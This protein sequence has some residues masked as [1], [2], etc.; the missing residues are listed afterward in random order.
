MASTTNRDCFI[1]GAIMK[2]A[3]VSPCKNGDRWLETEDL[4]IFQSSQ[5]QKSKLDVGEDAC[6]LQSQQ[7]LPTV[8]LSLE[9]IRAEKCIFL[10]FQLKWKSLSLS[11]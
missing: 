5:L 9:D 8:L 3:H 2:E 10:P 4:A 1:N 7:D 11:I 6:V